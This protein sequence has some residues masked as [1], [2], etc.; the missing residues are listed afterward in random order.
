ME[1]LNDVDSVLDPESNRDPNPEDYGWTRITDRSECR[2][3]LEELKDQMDSHLDDIDAFL[4]YART[5]VMRD[6]FANYSDFLD[7]I[8]PNETFNASSVPLHGECLDLKQQV[9]EMDDIIF[10]IT[11]LGWNV[12]LS[13]TYNEAYKYAVQ[14]PLLYRRRKLYNESYI[15]DVHDE[16]IAKCNWLM[17]WGE[18]SKETGEKALDD[19]EKIM[20]E[21]D[22]A[23]RHF[24]SIGRLFNRLYNKVFN[25]ILP[26]VT[27]GDYYLE[28]NVTKLTLSGAFDT[29]HFR[30]VVDELS[31]LSTDLSELSNTYANAMINGRDKF[32]DMYEKM[33]SLKL[34]ILNLMT[35]NTLELVKHAAEIN[36]SRMQDL[37]HN[38]KENPRDIIE[39]VK[40]TY[41]RCDGSYGVSDTT[42][43]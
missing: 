1:E 12:S 8:F 20:D 33:L 39:L 23:L 27:L 22:T 36:D 16:V 19:F 30:K 13:T 4:V 2:L 31:D 40:E 32:E 11:D 5:R 37:V 24:E 7:Y 29:I 15:Y 41:N 28:G 6:K 35:V 43:K 14:I 21:R 18:E 34:P 38:L 26:A 42:S 3:A 25:K 10:N 9:I 17:N